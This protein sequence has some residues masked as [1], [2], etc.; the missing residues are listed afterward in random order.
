MDNQQYLCHK[1]LKNQICCRM[2]TFSIEKNLKLHKL[3]IETIVV[4]YPPPHT[5]TQTCR[6]ESNLVF[7]LQ[8]PQ[9]STYH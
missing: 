8:Y 4:T 9:K 7:L 5:H 6:I 1:N 3:L 2:Y